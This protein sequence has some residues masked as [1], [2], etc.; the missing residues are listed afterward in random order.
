MDDPERQDTQM[1]IL[2]KNRIAV[3]VKTPE[4]DARLESKFGRATYLLLVDPESLA[5]EA[6][7]NPA[8]EAR[9]GA[10]IEAAELLEKKRVSGVIA[11]KFGPKAHE[12]LTAAAIPMYRCPAKLSVRDALARFKAGELP[13]ASEAEG[14]GRRHR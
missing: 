7:E 8:R 10:G 1:A 14:V 12:A 6:L 9:G 5:F 2:R 4:L 13:K 11:E 3:P